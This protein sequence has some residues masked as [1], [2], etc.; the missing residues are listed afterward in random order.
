MFRKEFRVQK[1]NLLK[2]SDLRRVRADVARVY[3]HLTEEALN[4]L[5]PLKGKEIAVQTIS[6]SRMSILCSDNVPLFFHHPS[7]SPLYIP[8]VYTLW[9]VPTLL[10]PTFS[11]HAPVFEKLVGGA[12]LMLPGVIV[13]KDSAYDGGRPL[14]LGT[15]TAGS[16]CAMRTRHNLTPLA[17]GIT[18][19][20]SQNLVQQGMKGKG[21]EILH[22]FMDKLWESGSQETPP[23]IAPEPT[24]A[25][26]ETQE[27]K[28]SGVNEEENGKGEEDEEK[29]TEETDQVTNTEKL[30]TEEESEQEKEKE[31]AEE[32][33][34]GMSQDELCEYC[35]MAAI[36]GKGQHSTAVK[37]KDLPIL[38]NVFFSNHMIA[39]QQVTEEKLPALQIKK[40]KWKKLGK[41]L[42]EMQQRGLIVMKETSPG[43]FQIT[44]INRNHPNYKEFVPLRAAAT[45]E[46]AQEEQTGDIIVQEMY[47]FP[48]TLYPLLPPVPQE[49]YTLAEA[50]TFL[51]NYVKKND[52]TSETNK[53]MVKLNLFLV[54]NVVG[55]KHAVAGSEIPKQ[56]LSELFEHKLQGFHMVQRGP[57]SEVRK[58]PVKPIHIHTE[59]RQGRKVM[60]C[61]SG[62]E[63]FFIP[64]D[65][66]CKALSKQFAASGTVTELPGKKTPT[67]AP[68]KEVQVQ[69][70]WIKQ[71]A[72][73]LM[74]NHQIP[75]KYIVTLDKTSKKK[76]G[77]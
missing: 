11:I 8:T 73:H 22:C 27:S 59:Q 5:L 68:N 76:R 45:I 66:L 40:T 42:E 23:T 2:K 50:R 15:W 43:V 74:D 13:P 14:A 6:G 35:F 75:K 26:G 9:R 46:G 24:P 3:P 49:Y 20:S 67:A 10:V 36:K 71:A 77:K 61:I 18:C 56:D 33:E 55:K 65:Q 60:T 19:V 1:K 38:A 53:K 62:L 34:S 21:V 31:E 37:D 29:Q 12:D 64:P 70:S 47:K 25:S 4:E 69:G 57:F 52:L 30:R 72:Q 16:L 17:V 48:K 28:A 51:W 54:D 32:E 39:A 63:T 41:F 7:G 58:G 44:E